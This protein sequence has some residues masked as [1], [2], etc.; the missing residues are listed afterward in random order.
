M[1]REITK[2]SGLNQRSSELAYKHILAGYITFAVWTKEECSDSQR[3]V[4][5]P[6]SNSF[7]S[8][9]LLSVVHPGNNYCSQMTCLFEKRSSQ[10]GTTSSVAVADVFVLT[11]LFRPGTLITPATLS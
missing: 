9:I 5:N 10:K 8:K 6:V 2:R 3:A 1:W 4:H 11:A 7:F